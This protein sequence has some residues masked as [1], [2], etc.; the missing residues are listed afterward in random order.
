MLTALP[1][2]LV[3]WFPH[4]GESE[5]LNYPWD[6]VS[7]PTFHLSW[8][9]IPLSTKSRVLT[10]ARV[11]EWTEADASPT[12]SAISLLAP[13]ACSHCHLLAAPWACR[14]RHQHLI[15]ILLQPLSH[16]ENFDSPLSCRS[17]IPGDHHLLPEGFHPADSSLL[18][19]MSLRRYLLYSYTVVLVILLL[20]CYVFGQESF[21]L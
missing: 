2:F 11:A 21:F 10:N 12:A 20:Y 6:Y 1:G 14:A 15:W 3:P 17:H 13:S 18:F 4:N 8:L 9:P 5:H 7:F 16:L 19:S